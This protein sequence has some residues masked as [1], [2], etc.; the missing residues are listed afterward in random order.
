MI[1]GTCSLPFLASRNYIQS[2][3]FI[4]LCNDIAKQHHLYPVDI[5][6]KFF[7]PLTKN[8]LWYWVENGEEVPI[9]PYV[10]CHMV[11][12]KLNATL[13]FEN[14]E[15][16][17]KE[18]IAY[19]EDVFIQSAEYGTDAASCTVTEPAFF[20]N[21]CVALGKHL[22]IHITGK[23]S[24]WFVT[25]LDI[26]N[27]ISKPCTLKLSLI[28]LIGNAMFR[29]AIYRNDVHCGQIMYRNIAKQTPSDR[30]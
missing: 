30:A 21:S 3:Q 13:Y 2:T 23:Q 11:A 27:L 26:H 29:L 6:A 1:R 17:I 22:A 15:E 28:N 19:S 18:R 20:V 12:E 4:T 10:S 16:E 9:K 24:G 14:G 5:S 25:Q 7:Q 8:I